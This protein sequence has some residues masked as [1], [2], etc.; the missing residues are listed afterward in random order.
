MRFEPLGFLAGG[1][2]RCSG[3]IRAA[4]VDAADQAVFLPRASA[5]LCVRARAS[6]PVGA[7]GR[8]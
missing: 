1:G 3:G 2:G 5:E 4:S 6:G 8:P 7:G